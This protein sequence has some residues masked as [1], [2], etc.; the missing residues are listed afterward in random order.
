M[1]PG[2]HTQAAIPRDGSS[3]EYIMANSLEKLGFDQFY[4]DQA[5]PVRLEGL[6]IARVIAVHKESYSISDGENTVLAELVGKLL[7]SAASPIDYPTVGD[8]VVSIFLMI[9]RLPL[10]MRSCHVNPC[11]REKHPVGKWTFN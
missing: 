10:S 5:L 8:W 4:L 7:Y 6:E 9:K 2:L 11:S 1:L 3:L